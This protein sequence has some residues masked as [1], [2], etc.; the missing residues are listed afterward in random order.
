MPRAA[1]RSQSARP[2]E[3]SVQRTPRLQA[4][5]RRQADISRT[6]RIRSRCR[7]RSSAAGLPRRRAAGY[8]ACRGCRHVGAEETFEPLP[9]VLASRLPQRR[10][11]NRA[12]K[13]R[14]AVEE[15]GPMTKPRKLRGKTRRSR[16]RGTCR[17]RS[18]PGP[19]SVPTADGPWPARGAMAQRTEPELSSARF[20][21][22]MRGV[23]SC[24]SSGV[25]RTQA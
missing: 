14:P 8:S 6:R 13:E 7:P 25:G 17:E 10:R 11:W 1:S 18:R 9:T 19:P 16:R 24:L 20:Q 15:G 22:R 3:S 4:R 23:E 5:H 12:Y 21:S 2:P